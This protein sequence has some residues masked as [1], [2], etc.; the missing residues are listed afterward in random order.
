L[1]HDLVKIDVGLRSRFRKNVFFARLSIKTS[2][3]EVFLN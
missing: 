2:T 1:F 3:T